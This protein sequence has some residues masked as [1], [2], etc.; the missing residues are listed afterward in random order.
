ME[1]TVEHREVLDDVLAALDYGVLG[2]DGAVGGDAELERGEEGVRHLVSR[3][4]D[5][6]VL[7]EALGKEVA[8]G[9]VFLVEREDGCV[10]DTCVEVMSV[11]AAS[12]GSQVVYARVSSFHSTFFSPSSSRN[13]SNLSNGS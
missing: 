6:R 5:V 10:G 9:V 2:G 1:A 12:R 11:D 7:E 8:E 13:S 4:C 3:E